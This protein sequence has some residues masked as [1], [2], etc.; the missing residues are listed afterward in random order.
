MNLFLNNTF[1]HPPIQK[2]ENTFDSNANVNK[3]PFTNE[4]AA[5]QQTINNQHQK[6]RLNQNLLRQSLDNKQHI[7]NLR[8]SPQKSFV[9]KSNRLNKVGGRFLP[10]IQNQKNSLLKPQSNHSKHLSFDTS[11]YTQTQNNTS[12]S[13]LMNKKQA[14]KIAQKQQLQDEEDFEVMVRKKY[15]LDDQSLVGMDYKERNRRLYEMLKKY[16]ICVIPEIENIDNLPVFSII[17]TSLKD[18]NKK[19]KIKRMET[20]LKNSSPS[21]NIAKRKQQI[22]LNDSPTKQQQNRGGR[23]RQTS[24][25][26]PKNFKGNIELFQ[27]LNDITN[28]KLKNKIDQSDSLNVRKRRKGGQFGGLV[29]DFGYEETPKNKKE[30]SGINIIEFKLQK[31]L[32]QHGRNLDEIKQDISDLKNLQV[33]TRIKDHLK[34]RLLSNAKVSVN[35]IDEIFEMHEQR[36]EDDQ[37][38]IKQSNFTDPMPGQNYN[39][40]NNDQSSFHSKHRESLPRKTINVQSN[41]LNVVS[42]DQSKDQNGQSEGSTQQTSRKLYHR[43]RE[44]LRRKVRMHVE[45]EQLKTTYMHEKKKLEY[46]IF[47]DNQKNEV[48]QRILHM[49]DDGRESP[50]PVYKYEQIKLKFKEAERSRRKQFHKGQ[51]GSAF[52]IEDL[53]DENQ[54][55]HVSHRKQSND[56][57]F[58]QNNSDQEIS[59][60]NGSSSEEV[61]QFNQDQV[62]DKIFFN[63]RNTSARKSSDPTKGVK[64]TLAKGI[65]LALNK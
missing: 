18:T 24:M 13:P 60:D 46:Q 38:V 17:E 58:K 27:H 32:T 47:R 2:L 10:N 9:L 22:N 33:P 49:V 44:A 31:I 4:G 56:N 26:D 41:K 15:K 51:F 12:L 52:S 23:S 54:N 25:F 35:N 37:F 29:E 36:E 30:S 1:H 55:N 50:K 28:A 45:N 19:S 3:Y 39:H 16:Q 7:Y 40:H 5:N 14:S 11:H 21:Q 20:D 64:V 59:S 48:T 42:L 57:H 53:D 6:N 43:F 61:D 62:L 65:K 34:K 8:I 63:K